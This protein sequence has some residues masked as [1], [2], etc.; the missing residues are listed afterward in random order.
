MWYNFIKVFQS[1]TKLN[2]AEPRKKIA[3]KK[4]AR[5]GNGLKDEIL[6]AGLDKVKPNLPQKPNEKTKKE[7]PQQKL[8][9]ALDEI[10]SSDAENCYLNYTL[11]KGKVSEKIKENRR[12]KFQQFKD[13]FRRRFEKRVNNGKA[14]GSN[15]EQELI[16]DFSDFIQA[17]NEP[18][19]LA[20]LNA[21]LEK[22]AS[23]HQKTISAKKENKKKRNFS[24]KENFG[25][26]GKEIW[27]AVITFKENKK[28]RSL[29][30]IREGEVAIR[31]MTKRRFKELDMKNLRS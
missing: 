2:M 9:G 25:K 30:M 19:F 3:E 29:T 15:F 20:A 1:K 27:T 23:S 4:L 12:K 22:F 26:N 14:V 28:L 24:Q 16:K 31:K 17:K 11:G 21:S 7:S 6:K 5:A 8:K 13:D 18:S 10:F